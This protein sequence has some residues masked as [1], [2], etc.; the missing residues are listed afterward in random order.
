M[1]SQQPQST[2]GR[3]LIIVLALA[4]AVLHQDFWWWDNRVGDTT[5]EPLFGF[6]PI[7]LAWH[8]GISI[9]AA[10]VGWLAI[11]YCWPEDLETPETDASD[12]AAEEAT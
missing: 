1:A 3:N 6:L 8:V 4:L 2:A 9:G 5:I 10:V 11:T 12:Q 7:G